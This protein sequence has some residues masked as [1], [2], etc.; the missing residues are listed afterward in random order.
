M[1]VKTHLVKGFMQL[2]KKR[3]H[4]GGTLKLVKG[5]N[6]GQ[7]VGSAVFFWLCVTKKSQ[8]LSKQFLCFHKAKRKMLAWLITVLTEYSHVDAS[9]EM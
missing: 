9:Y 4:G 3:R 2:H 6:M 8:F 1:S 7:C 5:V